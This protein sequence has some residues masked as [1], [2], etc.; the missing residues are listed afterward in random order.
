MER[1]SRT[2][3]R[4]RIS[5]GVGGVGNGQTELA[6]GVALVLTTVPSAM[7]LGQVNGQDCALGKETGAASV[8]TAF[9]D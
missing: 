4:Q 9:R 6:Q 1:M 7:I 5:R 3:L 8:K 2:S